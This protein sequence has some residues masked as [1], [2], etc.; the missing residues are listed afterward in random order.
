MA[1]HRAEV[2]AIATDPEP[3]TFENTL[4][5][6][7]RSGRSCSR[8]S[9]AV[10]RHVELAR[11][12]RGAGD[13]GRTTRPRLTAHGDAVRLDPR[14]YA[15]IQAR[16]RRRRDEL[17]LDPESATSRRAP[18]HRDRPSPAPGSTR[19]RRSGCVRSTS[20]RRPWARSSRSACSPTPTTSPSSSTTSP[21][22]TA[23]TAGE[24]SA[25]AAGG[26]AS[27]GH[28]GAWLHHAR[29]ADR[30]PPPG[31]A[32]RP[33]PARAACTRRRAPAGNRGNDH[34]TK[35][36]VLADRP[37]PRRAG[38][39]ARL[40]HARRA[41]R[42]PTRRRAP[43]ERVTDLLG[44]LAPAAARNIEAERALLEAEAGHPVEAHDWAFWAERVRA[45]E[46]RRRPR[47]DAAV[48]RGRAG[49]AATASSTR[50]SGSTA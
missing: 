3:P 35:A 44:R 20:A 8:A 34:D 23:S 29:A 36:L 17:G 22:S 13:R 6:L 38:P 37:A 47:G 21:S 32:D 4:V 7:E 27:T 26:R 11:H 14:L 9:L 41:R 15:R 39:A 28:E 43:P 12:R 40:R 45:D 18:P 19:A 33:G 2:E 31:L 30:T 25:A 46:V 49:A 10:L 50:P 5:A 42:S 48:L 24:I 1:E 16:P